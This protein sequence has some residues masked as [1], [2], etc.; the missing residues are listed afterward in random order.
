MARRRCRVFPS[1]SEDGIDGRVQLGILATQRT[2]GIDVHFD[3][4]GDAVILD[5]PAAVRET[6]SAG[7]SSMAWDGKDERGRVAA[8]GVYIMILRSGNEVARAKLI[9]FP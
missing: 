2:R 6:L 5:V 4:G 3:V 7:Q 9:R 8:A 1:L